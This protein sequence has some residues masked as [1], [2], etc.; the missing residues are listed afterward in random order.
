VR[1]FHCDHCRQAIFFEN[2]ICGK[3]G[4][5]LAYLPDLEIV[6]SLDPS[7]GRSSEVGGP[8]PAL[9]TPPVPRAK[10][11]TYRLCA[12]YT[13]HNICNWAIPADRPD[14]LCE[15][16]R[17]TRVIPDLG[18]PENRDLWCR[19]EVAKR[20]LVYSLL[21]FGL[22]V[23]PKSTD[24]PGGIEFRFIGDPPGGPRVLTGHDNGIITVNIAEAD[25]VERERARVSMHEPYRTLLG[26]FRHEIGHY[27]WDL[28]IKN[29]PGIAAFRKA[30]GDEQVNYDNALQS[31]YRDGAKKDWQQ[32]FVSPYASVHPWEDFAETW[33][34]YL[35]MSDAIETAAV[36]GLSLEP[37]RPDEPAMRR[38]AA[39][40]SSE[41]PFDE[42]IEDWF[43]LTYVLNNLNRGMGLADAYPFVLPG[44]TIEK[45]RFVHDLV[46]SAGQPPKA[47][48]KSAESSRFAVPADGSALV[49]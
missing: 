3:C 39:K 11:K 15:S 29:S 27:Y 14:A 35:H 47:D 21:Q 28:L 32:S 19:L 25:D 4:H 5:T 16:C 26:H 30:F 37:D 49:S 10:G 23:A 31:Y 46:R 33:A 36:C 44:P 9:W 8:L 24:N 48:G 12:N 34:H 7:T 6:A 20:R 2:T 13:E 22:P 41:L 1:V 45:I 18:R 40:R 17:L 42:L 38:P 43:A